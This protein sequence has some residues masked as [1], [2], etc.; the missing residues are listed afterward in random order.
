ML[1]WEMSFNTEIYAYLSQVVVV[2]ILDIEVLLLEVE[3]VSFTPLG[4][5]IVK[6]GKLACHVWS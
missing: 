1:L 6:L 2:D 4:Q 3:Q 5:V